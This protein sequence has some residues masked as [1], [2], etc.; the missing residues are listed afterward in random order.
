M[1]VVGKIIW[2]AIALT[3]VATFISFAPD[4]KRYIKMERM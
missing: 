3:A 2:S 1:K 4:M